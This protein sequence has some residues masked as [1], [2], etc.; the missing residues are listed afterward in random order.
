[1]AS[2]KM[3]GL[4]RGKESYKE[5]FGEAKSIKAGKTSPQQYARGE[6]SEDMK[7]AAAKKAPFKKK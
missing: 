4:F 3:A 6:K 2:S 1:M 7:K 5:E